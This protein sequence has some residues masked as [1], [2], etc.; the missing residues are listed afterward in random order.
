[1]EKKFPKKADIYDYDDY[2]YDKVREEEDEYMEK[3]YGID[4]DEFES[5]RGELNKNKIKIK[6]PESSSDDFTSDSDVDVKHPLYK[7]KI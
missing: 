7:K 6:K 3:H 4:M 5:L 1:M 2:I